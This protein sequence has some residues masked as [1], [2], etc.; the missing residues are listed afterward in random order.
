MMTRMEL[1]SPPLLPPTPFALKYSNKIMEKSN[2]FEKYQYCIQIN[3]YS[4][5]CVWVDVIKNVLQNVT[6][7]RLK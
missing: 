7:D 5:T 4:L 3:K 6:V 2:I 1:V